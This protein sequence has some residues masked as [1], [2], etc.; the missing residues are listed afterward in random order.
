VQL[1]KW[2]HPFL[3]ELIGNLVYKKT[4]T[5]QIWSKFRKALLKFKISLIFLS[6]P[7]HLVHGGLLWYCWR[8]LSMRKIKIITYAKIIL[9][10]SIYTSLIYICTQVTNGGTIYT[11]I[12]QEET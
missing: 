7:N 9:S 8:K 11:F 4:S 10:Q 12:D 1:Y 5:L 6:H 2:G 3:E